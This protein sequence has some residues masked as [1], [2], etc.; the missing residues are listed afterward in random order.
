MSDMDR[1]SESEPEEHEDGSDRDSDEH[2]DSRDEAS[3]EE[4]DGH[5]DADVAPSIDFK[6]LE[7]CSTHKAG[8][9][10]ME[11]TKCKA[12]L[13]LVSDQHHVKLLTLNSSKSSLITRYSGRCDDVVPTLS[14]SEATVEVAK[15]TF[16]KG[17]FKEKKKW[18]DIVKKFLTLP[19]SQHELLG[20]DLKSEDILKR[21]RNEKRFQHIFKY[22]KEVLESLRNLRI[23]QRPLLLL[24]EQN[25]ETIDSV[26]K[27][28]EA[29]GLVYP[30]EAPVRI[31]N[32]VPR[33]GHN[34]NDQ[35]S[36]S[37]CRDMLPRPDIRSIA[38]AAALTEEQAEKVVSY[39][40]TY[41]Q[42]WKRVWLA[43]A[44]IPFHWLIPFLFSSLFFRD[45][46]S[47]QYVELFDTSARFLNNVEDTLV[48]YTD[49]YSHVDASFR[50]LIREKVSSLFKPDIKADVMMKTSSKKMK[51]EKPKG[52][53][54]G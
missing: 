33:E 15:N 37:S 25:S 21:Y 24:I 30:K 20:A 29:A 9:M 26:R 43:F 52:L 42:R 41:R 36:F 45:S 6:N 34:L 11:C 4:S 13:A 8:D 53:F 32:N 47:K 35:L 40:D 51:D 1:Y 16:T 7:L 14:L 38:E 19:E 18:I 54:G 3:S 44:D 2:G 49:L 10:T 12:A 27:L 28:G 23:A 5:D 39:F 46:V 31:G 17:M 48:F 50:E 22:Q